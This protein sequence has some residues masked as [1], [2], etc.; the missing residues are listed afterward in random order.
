VAVWCLD[1]DGAVVDGVAHADVRFVMAGW[2]REF[3]VP[4]GAADRS[5]TRV[6]D[7]ESL[8]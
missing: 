1:E 6:S 8:L 4:F 5:Q 7:R 3:L 2:T